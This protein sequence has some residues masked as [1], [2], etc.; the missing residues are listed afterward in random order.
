MSVKL[1]LLGSPGSGKSTVARYIESLARDEHWSFQWI[2]DYA[3]LREMFEKDQQKGE[4]RF[5]PAC[6]GG[7]DVLKFEVFDEA[8]QDLEQRSELQI[9]EGAEPGIVLIEFARNDY[10]QAL[11]QF[12]HGFLQDAYFL[13]LD[14]DI[15]ICKQRIDARVAKPETENDYYVSD[16]IFQAYYDH[17]NGQRLSNILT[18]YSIDRERVKILENNEELKMAAPN[19]EEFVRPIICAVASAV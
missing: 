2:N 4:G 10:Q 9:S 6:H 1:F 5:K 13:Y 18:E 7:F 12:S 16:Y 15:D 19:I 8:L 14:T 17:A 11:Q 3:I